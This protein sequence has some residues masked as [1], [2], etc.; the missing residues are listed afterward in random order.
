MN[1]RLNPMDGF[2]TSTESGSPYKDIP[3]KEVLAQK[4]LVKNPDYDPLDPDSPYLVEREFHTEFVTSATGGDI[5]LMEN[6]TDTYNQNA[7][8]TSIAEILTRFTNGDLNAIKN[9]PNSGIYGDFTDVP[10]T[11]HELHQRILDAQ[12]IFSHLP[13]EVKKK[14]G[15]NP[16]EWIQDLGSDSWNEWYNEYQSQLFDN[17]VIRNPI[18]DKLDTIASL[19]QKGDE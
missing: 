11:P 15:N 3:R 1:F 8:G 6:L 5:S 10:Q 18:E 12:A 2:R 7:R 9:N 14:Y 19:L 13:V 17:S 4:T 16:Y